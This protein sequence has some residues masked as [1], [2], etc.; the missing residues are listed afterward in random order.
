M[1]LLF[2]S[3]LEQCAD[4]AMRFWA[5]Y[6]RVAGKLDQFYLFD[7]GGNK[8]Q[9]KLSGQSFVQF[10]KT[11]FANSNSHSL[12]QGCK[13]VKPDELIP[14][15][16]FVQNERGGVGHVSVIIDVC[17][18]KEGK[19]LFLIGYSFMPAQEFHIE[20]AEEK[21]GI[22]GW[23]TIE[24]YTQYLKEYLDFGKPVLRRFEPL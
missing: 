24:G 4:F 23:F 13:P 19:R 9:F 8:K 1:P 18:S 21:Y 16:L 2:R 14:G 5:E 3:N 10:L 12:K 15:D 11:S 22:Q 6:H 20:K 7:Y 17:Q